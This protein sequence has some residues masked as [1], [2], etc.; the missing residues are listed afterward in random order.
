MGEKE[1]EESKS[2]LGC[3]GIRAMETAQGM[4]V[5]PT[6][7]VW[8]KRRVSADSGTLDKGLLVCLQVLYGEPIKMN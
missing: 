8:L 3:P 1:A 7:S 2:F 6:V 4:G 5:Y